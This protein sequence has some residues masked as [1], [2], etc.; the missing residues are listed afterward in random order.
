MGSG[1]RSSLP[2][3]P[4]YANGFAV[5]SEEVGREPVC[6]CC[7]SSEAGTH[8]SQSS[9]TRHA[10]SRLRFSVHAEPALAAAASRSVSGATAVRAGL[11]SNC[12]APM[13]RLDG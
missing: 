1:A 11:G 4:G 5:V 3:L 2:H 7:V 6:H 8:C 9:G 13:S 12:S 10:H